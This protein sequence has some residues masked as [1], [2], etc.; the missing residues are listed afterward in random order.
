M[1][2]E[3]ALRKLLVEL[4][5]RDEPVLAA[6]LLALPALARRR[7]DGQRELGNLDEQSLF[8]GALAG[9]RGTGDYENRFRSA[10]TG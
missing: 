8:Q 6:V 2:E 7:R 3:L 1:L 5:V 4:R 10:A 9:A